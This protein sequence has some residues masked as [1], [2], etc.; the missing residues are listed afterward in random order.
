MGKNKKT[1]KHTFAMFIGF[2]IHYFYNKYKYLR[3]NNK[4]WNVFGNIE[5]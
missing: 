5:K 3:E 1:L 2:K 4:R